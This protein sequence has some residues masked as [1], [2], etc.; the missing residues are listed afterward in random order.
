VTAR[1]R[2]GVVLLG[3]VLLGAG[4]AAKSDVFSALPPIPSGGKPTPSRVIWHDLLTADP[5][6][7]Q[8]FYGGL[9]GW[10]FTPVNERY[11]LVHN[12]DRVIGGIATVPASDGS[13]WLPQFSTPD[14]DRSLYVA[15]RAG[16]TVLLGP[17]D[18]G[19]RGR[20]AI[21]RDPQAAIFGL[22]QTRDGDPPEVSPKNGDWL[23]Q[24]AW[25]SDLEGAKAYYP[26]VLGF[27]LGTQK[28]GSE[29]YQ[30]FRMAESA[31][32]GVLVKP[33]PTLG[34]AWVSYV[35]VAD[36]KAV[37]ARATELGGRVLFAP[38]PGVRRGSLAIL[39]DPGGAGIVVQQW[40]M[41]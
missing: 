16:G 3:V 11:A 1:A 2:L 22:I 28:I 35:R 26:Q 25:V 32:A 29:S 23:W 39:A 9:F 12:G 21:V 7:A 14:I 36:I 5:A 10:Q 33:D 13:Q 15:S 6:G 41:P 38:D 17:I 27:V 40:P 34:N 19:A 8:R 31:R 20:M 24:E 30:Y 18:V 37:V 4:C